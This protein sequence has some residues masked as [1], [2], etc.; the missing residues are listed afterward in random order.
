MTSIE[1]TNETWN[2]VTGCTKVSPGCAN[3]YA[4]GVA[5]R[6]WKGRPFTDVQCHED[7]LTQPLHWRKPRRVFVNSMSDLFHADVPI[8]FLA[9]VFDV[10]A[11]A[12]TPC[13][14]RHKHEDECWT[15]VPHTYQVLTKRPERMHHLL[16]EELPKFLDTAWPGDST[17]N[18]MREVGCWPLPNVWLGVSVENQPTAD[19]RI[20][21]LLDTPAAVRFVSCEPLLEPVDLR[22]LSVP[23]RDGHAYHRDA[24][25]GL[26]GRDYQCGWDQPGETAWDQPDESGLASLDWVIVGGE[27]GPRARP[28]SA[29]W[30]DSLVRDCRETGVPVFVK[31]LGA[32]PLIAGAT[33]QRLRN[34]K[35]GDPAEWPEDLRVREWPALTGRETA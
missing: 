14:R 16:T 27:S 31:Q 17:V 12:T 23:K 13:R 33:P 19:K 8:E 25:G 5:E 35:G 10:M 34:R 32:Q 22:W 7:R 24:L 4:E 26:A 6:F 18:I 29:W 15:G 30:I 21:V 20:P 28:C 2:P 3:C 9:Q 11:S 1:W